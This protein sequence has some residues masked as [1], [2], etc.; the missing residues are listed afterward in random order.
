MRFIR[1]RN[2]YS[3]VPIAFLNILKWAGLPITYKDYAYWKKKTKTDTDGAVYQD[4]FPVLNGI[5]YIKV[6][7][8]KVCDISSHIFNGRIIL[9]GSAWRAGHD[10]NKH[11]FLVTGEN[12][13]SFYCVNTY[14]GHLW[15]DKDLFKE[16]YLQKVKSVKT[17]PYLYSIEKVS[18]GNNGRKD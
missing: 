3:C 12:K 15:L 2:G 10:V 8:A 9:L 13:S 17:Y 18:G 5:K 11:L 7:K 6:K 4:W 16:Y 14:N 1:Q